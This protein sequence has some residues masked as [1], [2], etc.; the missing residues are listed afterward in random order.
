MISYLEEIIKMRNSKYMSREVI[1]ELRVKNDYG[2]LFETT[3]KEVK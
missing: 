3:K 2:M 1:A